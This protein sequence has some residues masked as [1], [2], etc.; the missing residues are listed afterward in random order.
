MSRLGP[1]DDLKRL[2]TLLEP[3]GTAITARLSVD[4]SRVVFRVDGIAPAKLGTP[5]G[6]ICDALDGLFTRRVRLMVSDRELLAHVLREVKGRVADPWKVK[7]REGTEYVDLVRPDAGKQ[8]PKGPLH[9][10]V[11]EKRAPIAGGHEPV[12]W[13]TKAISG[14]HLP[15]DLIGLGLALVL[16]APLLAA[17][18][19]ISI[20]AV[21]ALGSEGLTI[22]GGLFLILSASLIVIVRSVGRNL[23]PDGIH[24]CRRCGTVNRVL[25][26]ERTLNIECACCGFELRGVWPIRDEQSV[27]CVGCQAPNRVLRH[28]LVEGQPYCGECGKPLA[29]TANLRRPQ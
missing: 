11:R 19:R 18:Y 7:R 22:A 10:T 27:V 12:D 21:R 16:S 9:R 20:A 28:Q 26:F 14:V 13:R 29:T 3:L 24:R 17:F 15:T 8:Q 6:V 2:Q 23:R 5:L 25:P 4:G 1:D